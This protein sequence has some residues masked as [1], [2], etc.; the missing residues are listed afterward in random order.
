MAEESK[1]QGTQEQGAGLGLGIDLNITLSGL[2]STLNEVTSALSGTAEGLTSAVTNLVSQIRQMGVESFKSWSQQ[3]NEEQQQ[4]YQSVTDKLREAAGRGEDE[5][6]NL[7][8]EMGES[9]E[10]GGQ[11]MQDVAEEGRSH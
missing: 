7:L 11:K 4:T 1:S 10:H 5:A 9:V 3:G 6:R 2:R 8:S